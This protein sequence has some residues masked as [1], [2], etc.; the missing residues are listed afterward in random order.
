MILSSGVH[1]FVTNFVTHIELIIDVRSTGLRHLLLTCSYV[2][3]NHP[4]RINPNQT[5]TCVYLA[6]N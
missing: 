4:M 6:V 5:T 1:R 3:H 2:D